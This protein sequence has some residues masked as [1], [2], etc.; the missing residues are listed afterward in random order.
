MLIINLVAWAGLDFSYDHGA[1]IDLP[2]DVA[3]A[4]IDAGMAEPAPVEKPK[5]GKT[6]ERA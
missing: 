2:D 5:R 3:K 1:I 6:S 4:R